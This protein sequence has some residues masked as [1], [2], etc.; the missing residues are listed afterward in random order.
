MEQSGRAWHRFLEGWLAGL[1]GFANLH[2]RVR[3][4][5]LV[6]LVYLVRNEWKR[7]GKLPMLVIYDNDGVLPPG[8]LKYLLIGLAGLGLFGLAM[9]WAFLTS[10]LICEEAKRHERR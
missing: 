3:P 2:R 7:A 10:L 4:A 6:R 5:G 8:Y 1:R 9:A